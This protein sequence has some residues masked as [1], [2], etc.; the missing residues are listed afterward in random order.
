[1]TQRA[2]EIAAKVETFVREV[3]VPYERD[4]RC[5]PHGPTDELVQQLR[6]LARQAGVLT[7]H[8]LR[9]GSHLHAPVGDTEQ[10]LRYGQL[11]HRALDGA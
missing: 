11:R 6:G 3:V 2:H 4:P 7:P 9:D 1:M 8:I 5:G 10:G